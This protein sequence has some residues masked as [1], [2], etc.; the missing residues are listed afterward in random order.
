MVCMSHAAQKKI[1]VRSSEARVRSFSRCLVCPT[2]RATIR[3][4]PSTIVTPAPAFT[5]FASG[6]A[7]VGGGSERRLL[8][9][10]VGC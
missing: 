6:D 7:S 3:R 1:D 4:N 8:L 2:W 10:V 9:S 5:L